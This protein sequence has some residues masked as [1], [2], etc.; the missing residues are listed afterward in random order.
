MQG[1]TD[2]SAQ[3]SALPGRKCLELLNECLNGDHDC[4]ANADC[5]DTPDSF[6]CKCHQGTVDVSPNVALYPG[7]QCNPPPPAAPSYPEQVDHLLT[8]DLTLDLS[9]L[10]AIRRDQVAVLMRSV[11]LMRGGDIRVSAWIMRSV[12]MM[13]PVVVSKGLS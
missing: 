10:N 3:I 12:E 7:R 1:T 6:S 4:S 9:T 5:I 13:E 8:L 2:I 11:V